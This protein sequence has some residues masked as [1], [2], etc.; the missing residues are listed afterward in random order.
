MKLSEAKPQYLRDLAINKSKN[1]VKTYATT[2]NHLERILGDMPVHD[3][4]VGN[5]LGFVRQ[6][7][8]EQPNIAPNTLNLHITAVGSFMHWLLFQEE[9]GFTYQAF[10]MLRERLSWMRP[11]IQRPLPRPAPEESVKAVLELAAQKNGPTAHRNY[12][13]LMTIAS[14]GGRI[15]EILSLKVGDLR[16]N[17]TAKIKGKRGKERLLLF[18]AETFDVLMDYL[19]SPERRNDEPNAHVFCRYDYTWEERKHISPQHLRAHILNPLIEEAGVEPFTPHQL[20]HR[21]GTAFYEQTGD[22][23]ATQEAMGHADMNTTRIYAEVSAT[24]LRKLRD[25]V[26]LGK[27]KP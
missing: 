11:E 1:T 21:F 25:K 12:A 9:L 19:D 4:E 2:L 7:C 17:L 24:R 5:I 16:P 8:E 13:L 22:I 15:S 23:A 3:L 26:K 18:D 6:L 14:T 20:R 10:E 27:E